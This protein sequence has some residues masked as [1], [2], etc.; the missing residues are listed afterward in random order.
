[1]KVSSHAERLT[2]ANATA[3]F[4]VHDDA[5]AVRRLL[6]RGMD[7]PFPLLR[8]PARTAYRLWGLRRASFPRVW[9]DPAVWRQYAH[10][11]GEGERLRGMGAD[12]RQ[13]GGDFVVDRDGR[14]LY[15]RP[16]R[17]DDRP[18]VG[19]LLQAVEEP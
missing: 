18:P 6:L 11:L 10:L 13:L 12:V 4:V 14:I 9:L 2:A 3:A 1:M 7:C 17:R 19:L 8:D 5:D 16:Q 15:S